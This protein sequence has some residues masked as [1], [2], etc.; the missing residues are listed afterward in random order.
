M[1]S[2]IRSTRRAPW[3]AR[4]A[5]ARG[6]HNEPRRGANTILRCLSLVEPLSYA[7]QA[8]APTTTAAVTS[9]H[10]NN[11]ITGQGQPT[12]TLRTTLLRPPPPFSAPVWMRCRRLP[13]YRAARVTDLL[14]ASQRASHTQRRGISQCPRYGPSV[15]RRRRLNPAKHRRPCK[16]GGGNVTPE[17][18]KR[19]RPTPA[20]SFDDAAK[21]PHSEP[22]RL[23]CRAY[24]GVAC[25]GWWV[26]A[27]C[28]SQVT[29]ADAAALQPW[30]VPACVFFQC[31][32]R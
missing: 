15:R 9:T 24:R 17:R 2:A 29:A 5:R 22:S 25:P 11:A 4:F 6:H 14:I 10:I 32:T 1:K 12:V 20:A 31:L 26:S 3:R 19:S 7:H 8:L 13:P 16:R 28:G 23:R 18:R 30:L 21:P 27:T